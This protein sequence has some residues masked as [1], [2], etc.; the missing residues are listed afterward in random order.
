VRFAAVSQAEAE[1]LAA[2][3]RRTL[4]AILVGLARKPAGDTRQRERRL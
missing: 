4:A 1:D 3:E 2:E